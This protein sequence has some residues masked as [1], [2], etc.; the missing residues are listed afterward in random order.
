MHLSVCVL[1]A[2][3]A[4]F[5]VP[6]SGGQAAGSAGSRPGEEEQ[7]GRGSRRWSCCFWWCGGPSERASQ[8]HQRH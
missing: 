4:V 1:G 8:S 5:S 6:E 3:Q 2:A 7:S